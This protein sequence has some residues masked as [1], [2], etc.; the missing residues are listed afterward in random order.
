MYRSHNEIQSNI[1]YLPC[2]I[3]S[4]SVIEK[5]SLVLSVEGDFFFFLYVFLYLYLTL[6]WTKYECY[7]YCRC[8]SLDIIMSILLDIRISILPY[9]YLNLHTPNDLLAIEII[10]TYWTPAMFWLSQ[11]LTLVGETL[12]IIPWPT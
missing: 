9:F 10:L 6:K 12:C 8:H 2:L 11:V 5:N 7:L 3:A 1:F 4:H